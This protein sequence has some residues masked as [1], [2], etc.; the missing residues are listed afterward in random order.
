MKKILV[1]FKTHLDV[2]FTDLSRN[3]VKKYNE[4]Y[5]PKA[6]QVGKELEEL[7]VKE[8]FIWTTGSWLIRQYL[9][10]ATKEQIDELD[11]AVKKG[12]ISWHGLPFTTHTE[13]MDKDLFLYG[14]NMA[15][16]LDTR[17]GTKTIG[18]KMTDVPGHTRAIVPLLRKA[19]VEFLHIGVNPVSAAAD[20]PSFFRWQAPT[21]EHINMMYNPGAYGEYTEIPGTGIGVYFAH[22]G[23][24]LGPTST[25]GVIKVYKQLHEKFP[26]AEIVAA[27]LNDVALAVREVEHTLPVITNEL[28]DNWIHG[29]G[30]DPKKV[31][32]FKALE[33]FAQNADEKTRDEIYK[34]I[35][36][37][38]E[39]TWGVD[40]KTWLHDAQHW[41]REKLA[42]ARKLDNF[43][44][45]EESWREQ[46]EYL[47][48]AVKSIS[49][50]EMRAKAEALLD[51]YRA[52]VPS[53]DGMKELNG[54]ASICGFD[55]KW[56]NTG[57]YELS[58][59]GKNIAS[60]D[61]KLGRFHYEIFG[62]TE[63]Q[64][65]FGLRYGKPELVLSWWA[66]YDFMKPGL[67]EVLTEHYC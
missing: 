1:L 46:R 34:N 26:E 38:P 19:G 30:T 49:N 64:Q 67:E 16:E 51:D 56:D 65:N 27:S 40:I 43:K 4:N 11:A 60:K 57:I 10:V 7:G 59:D 12:W 9:D 15:A 55:I 29:V 42:E 35:I 24:N 48:D 50:S 32:I 44:Y 45:A 33:R 8:G 37:I 17:Y 25:E 14:L 20:V 31:N 47:Y 39:H 36:M 3:I 58:K 66:P 63:I 5:I 52:D 2:G 53:F 22:T 62:S 23:D 41:T 18:A 28:G 61:N 54:E 13:L 21:G 6:I